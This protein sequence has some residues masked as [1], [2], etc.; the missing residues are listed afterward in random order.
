MCNIIID[1]VTKM[2]ELIQSGHGCEPTFEYFG[3]DA[4]TFWR[5]FRLQRTKNPDS[6]QCKSLKSGWMCYA[7]LNIIRSTKVV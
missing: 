5:A 1:A 4:S 3:I 7:W 2:F 6:E